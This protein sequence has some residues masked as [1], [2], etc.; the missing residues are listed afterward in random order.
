[1]KHKEALL[2]L[3]LLTLP[4]RM[5]LSYNK[6]SSICSANYMIGTSVI[7]FFKNILCYVQHIKLVCERLIFLCFSLNPYYSHSW[8]CHMPG[9]NYCRVIIFTRQLLSNQISR[10]K[11]KN[12]LSKFPFILVITHYH[13]PTKFSS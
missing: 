12:F 3:S 4:W 11:Y 1:M 5:S 10:G 13:W 7:V 9:L 8:K 2:S 6:Q